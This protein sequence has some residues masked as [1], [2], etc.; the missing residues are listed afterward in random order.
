MFSKRFCLPLCSF[1]LLSSALRAQDSS[2]PAFYEYIVGVAHLAGYDTST[3]PQNPSAT[4]QE[5]VAAYFWGAPLETTYRSQLSYLNSHGLSVNTLYAPGVIDTSTTVEAPDMNVLYTSG[6]LNLAGNSA[7]VLTVPNTTATNT[8]NIMEVV[9]AYGATTTSVGTRN[10]TTSAVNNSG[11][12]YL[13]VGPGYDTSQALPAGIIDYIQSD[14]AQSWLI[15]RMAVDNLATAIL[16]NGDPTPY[17]IIAGGAASPLSMGNSVPLAQAYGVTPLQTYLDTGTITPAITSSTPTPEQLAIAQANAVTKTGQEFYAYVGD[18]VAQNGVPSTPGNDQMAM[19]QNFTH[20]GLT[21]D[22]YTAPPDPNTIATMNQAA[23]DAANM[24]ETMALNTSKLPG[25]GATSTGW[26]VNTSL[27]EYPAT[28]NGWLTNALTSYIGTVANLA[29]D[30]TYP[31]TTISV[32]GATQTPLNGA[33]DYTISFEAGELPPVEGF[34]SITVYDLEGNIVPNTGNT[35]Y[36]DDVYQL[37]SMQMANIFGEALDETPITFYLSSTAP[38]D[39]SLM[40][41][42][43]PVP[44][45]EFELILRMYF[46]DST[47]P[48]ILNGT[49]AIPAVQMV[50]EPSTFILLGLGGVYLLVRRRRHPKSPTAAAS[51]TTL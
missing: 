15:G 23:N 10:F 17:S 13:M 5:A 27:G 19:Y 49:Y 18:S 44:D 32:D 30:G 48:S 34:W 29:V 50:P 24:L 47:D 40:P 41:F 3:L 26:T 33:N 45:E 6:F 46:P 7:F 38:T 20:I 8:Y 1:V 12:N 51:S 21:T 43:L 39:P 16:P 37:S 25:G 22:G 35:Y 28:Y 9:N 14:T 42:W 4:Y 36:G 11:G 31:Q 2:V